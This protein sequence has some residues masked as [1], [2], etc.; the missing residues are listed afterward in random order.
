[1]GSIPI[2]AIISFILFLL[3]FY[4]FFPCC[5]FYLFNFRKQYIDE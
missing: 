2:L 5:I 3:L 4:F 1:M